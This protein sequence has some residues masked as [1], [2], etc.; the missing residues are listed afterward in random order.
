MRDFHLRFCK[1]WFDGISDLL[2]NEKPIIPCVS[3]AY[4]LGSSDGTMF[5]YP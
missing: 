3:W 1:E 5:I 4:I 2:I